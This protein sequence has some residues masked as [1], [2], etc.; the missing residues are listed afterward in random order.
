[1]V[2]EAREIDLTATLTCPRCGAAEQL[3]MPTDYCLFF[4][5]CAACGARLRPM[6]GDCCVFC[7]YGSRACPP[8]QAAGDAPCCGGCAGV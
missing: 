1:M 7:S 2:T 5:D 8:K 4:H 3:A 6:P